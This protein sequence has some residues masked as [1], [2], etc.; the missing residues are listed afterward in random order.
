MFVVTGTAGGMAEW[1]SE[2]PLSQDSDGND[3]LVENQKL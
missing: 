3:K 1:E 2:F